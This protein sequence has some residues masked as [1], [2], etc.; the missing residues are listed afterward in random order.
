MEHPESSL[1]GYRNGRDGAIVS[2]RS[3]SP[4]GYR[5][6][7][8]PNSN[9]AIIALVEMLVSGTA[10]GN[11]TIA[12]SAGVH[13]L[14]TRM[15]PS[16]KDIATFGVGAVGGWIVHALLSIIP[17]GRG[18]APSTLK[19]TLPPPFSAIVLDRESS[20]KRSG[21]GIRSSYSSPGWRCRCRGCPQSL[22]SARGRS[23]RSLSTLKS[24]FLC[25]ISVWPAYLL[26]A[27]GEGPSIHRDPEANSGQKVI[28]GRQTGEWGL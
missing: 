4:G 15:N 13:G 6:S 26:L 20:G 11:R 17:A 14:R 28:V 12:P 8:Q 2:L 21:E 22:L 7:I 23:T 3:T 19:N 24:T 25:C 1:R 16:I 10:S 18:C 5:N 27:H 9:R